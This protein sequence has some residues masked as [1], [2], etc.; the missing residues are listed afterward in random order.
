LAMASNDWKPENPLT[1]L[2]PRESEL[3]RK[4]G[5]R[6]YSLSRRLAEKERERDRLEAE[7]R[8]LRELLAESREVRTVLSAQVESL[9]KESDRDYQERSELRRL[10]ASLHTQMQELLPVVTGLSRSQIAA[11]S[12]ASE[13]HHDPA[14]TNGQGQSS[15]AS[16]LFSA[17]RLEVRDIRNGRRRG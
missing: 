8:T 15:L 13:A 12:A 1:A 3:L 9:Q 2:T 7:T 6:V 16:R 10:L 5:E 11:S 4:A 14:S 17:A